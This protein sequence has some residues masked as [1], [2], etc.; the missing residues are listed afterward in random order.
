MADLAP[1]GGSFSVLPSVDRAL[2]VLQGEVTVHVDGMDPPVTL[3]PGSPILRFPG[4]VSTTSVVPADGRD[5][6]I[7]WDRTRVHAEVELCV[8][9]ATLE[10]GGVCY[11]VALEDTDL[12][13]FQLR[14]ED[15]F[16]I[17]QPVQLVTGRVLFVRFVLF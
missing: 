6:N 1:P 14:V 17:E 10:P 4:D 8:T 5:L 9:G 15:A 16:R 13:S 11:A 2:L 7:M 12:G 3:S